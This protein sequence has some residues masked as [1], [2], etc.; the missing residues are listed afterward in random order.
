MLTR[1]S[2]KGSLLGVEAEVDYPK[3]IHHGFDLFEALDHLCCGFV[4]V[5]NHE[6]LSR[7]ESHG[8][9]NDLVKL[10]GRQANLIAL[11]LGAPGLLFLHGLC[12]L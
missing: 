4:S 8:P 2:A 1:F 6:E 12:C 7:N 3:R 5:Y 9:S 10:L 11:D